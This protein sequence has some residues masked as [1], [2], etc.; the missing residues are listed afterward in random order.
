M[1]RSSWNI[2]VLYESSHWTLHLGIREPFSLASVRRKGS[3]SATALRARALDAK[4]TMGAFTLAKEKSCEPFHAIING[5]A[6]FAYEQ[7]I[8]NC[9]SGIRLCEVYIV[10]NFRILIPVSLL[11]ASL[12]WW[13]AT[14]K[15]NQYVIKWKLLMLT[16]SVY[17]TSHYK[18]FIHSKAS[19]HV[20][21]H[22]EMTVRHFSFIHRTIVAVSL[23]FRWRLSRSV[24]YCKISLFYETL[25][26]SVSLIISDSRTLVGCRAVSK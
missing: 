20:S 8:L 11:E 6:F 24:V 15:I 21:I 3:M 14:I 26:V 18:T 23:L 2:F 9:P 17:S 12:E 1:Q 5:G 19:T 22:N 10:S 7:S 25:R 4:S 16:L 13:N